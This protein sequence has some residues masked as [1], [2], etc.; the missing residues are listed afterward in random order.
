MS[1]GM[2]S[3]LCLSGIVSPSSFPSLSPFLPLSLLPY[4]IASAQTTISMDIP[5][6]GRNRAQL[7]MVFV[8]N[9][10]I[11]IK[12]GGLLDLIGNVLDLK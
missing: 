10:L 8:S 12:L 6:S 1:A 2:M 7:R 11:S 3:N 4:R 5:E 9:Y